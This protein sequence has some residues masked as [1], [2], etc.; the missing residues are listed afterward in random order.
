MIN[1]YLT[2]KNN[3]TITKKRNL[4]KKRKTKNIK[5]I[6]ENTLQLN[7]LDGFHLKLEIFSNQIIIRLIKFA[8]K[9]K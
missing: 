6:L 2:M 5:L 4:Q 3:K 1:I 8:K 7:N 9:I